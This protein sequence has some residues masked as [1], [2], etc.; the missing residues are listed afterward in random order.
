MIINKKMPNELSGEESD[1][2]DNV[3]SPLP[4]SI[5]AQALNVLQIVRKY[6]R[7]QPIIT[8]EIFF[9][10]N[11]VENFTDTFLSYNKNNQ[12][13]VYFFQK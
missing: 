2:D 1:I 5:F 12:K 3:E 6:I 13:Y 11:I 10:L 8:V 4:L 7:E 9:V